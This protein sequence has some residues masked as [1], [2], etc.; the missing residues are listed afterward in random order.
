MKADDM[1]E[2][3]IEEFANMLESGETVEFIFN[4][5]YYEILESSDMGY[6]VNV[7]S[8]NEKDEYD[9]YLDKHLIDGGLCSGCAKDAIGFML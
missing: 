2:V 4:G 6:V 8:D 9:D 7:Y 3:R 5:F 1:D